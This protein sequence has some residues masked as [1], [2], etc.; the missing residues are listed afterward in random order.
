MKLLAGVMVGFLCSATFL[1][2]GVLQCMLRAIPG[3]DAGKGSEGREV[4]GRRR[5]GISSCKDSKK[6]DEVNTIRGYYLVYSCK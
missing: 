6:I 1:P 2:F 4:G 5:G 3:G